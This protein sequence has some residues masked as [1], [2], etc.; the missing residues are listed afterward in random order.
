MDLLHALEQYTPWNDQEVQDHAQMLRFLRTGR[1]L[2]SRSSADAHWTASA[3]VV[4]PDR[5]QVLMAH[6]NLYRSWA[7][8][9]GHA[10]GDR[11]LL[12]VAM[13]EVQEESGTAPLF[14]VS[15]DIFSLEILAVAGHEKHGVYVPSHLHL[16]V[17]FLLE[18]DP[19]SPIRCKAD[20]NSRVSW[21]T[22]EDA[23]RASSEP[24]F[25]DR[26]YSKLIA[27]TALF[28]PIT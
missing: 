16:N 27:K 17:T 20:E 3:W 1:D 28:P 7:W 18:A 4:S 11:D 19:A 13:R 8:L 22:P 9:G 21:F 23:L 12:A 26:I 10:D 15:K 6:H 5:K 24:W 14:P 2:Y 25:R